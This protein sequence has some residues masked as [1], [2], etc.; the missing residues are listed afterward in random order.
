MKF[1]EYY[2][3][4]KEGKSNCV[5]RSF[6]KLYDKSYDEVYGSLCDIAKSLN[7]NSFNDIEVFEE[8]MKRHNTIQIN[9]QKEV[10]IKDL[11][12]D[13]GSYIVFCWDKNEYYH[14]NV[15]ID[16]VLYDKN[17]KGLELFPI[18]IYK[19]N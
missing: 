16:N 11:A 7:C 13:N 9:Y 12:L 3:E 1:K 5:I 4:N 18:K 10:M 14:M 8:Y 15:I 2:I 19:S 6:C 17:I